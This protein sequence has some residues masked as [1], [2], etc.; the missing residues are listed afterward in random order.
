MSQVG[1]IRA[2]WCCDGYAPGMA[3]AAIL[4]AET[5]HM[6]QVPPNRS[7]ES[8][9][10]GNPLAWDQVSVAVG[11]V[12][13]IKEHLNELHEIDVEVDFYRPL[14][15]KI[16]RALYGYDPRWGTAVG[17]E[18]RPLLNQSDLSLLRALG[19]VITSHARHSTVPQERREALAEKFLTLAEEVADIDYLSA[20]TRAYLVRLLRRAAETVR[21]STTS[22]AA[23]RATSFEVSGA[24]GAVAAEVSVPEERRSWWREQATAVGVSI[25]STIVANGVMLTAGTAATHLLEK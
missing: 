5:L 6:W 12:S 17:N 24:L 3:N 16:Y 25:I 19:Q 2:L 9:R 23:V 21:L 14:L 20:E 4:L 18:A 10:G 7:P 8:V 11:Y 22:D 15:P 13:E 1:G